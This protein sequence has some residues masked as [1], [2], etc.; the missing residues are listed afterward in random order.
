MLW[1]ICDKLWVTM[2]RRKIKMRERRKSSQTRRLSWRRLK[3]IE[4]VLNVTLVSFRCFKCV[5]DDIW[6]NQILKNP[7][8]KYLLK[9]NFRNSTLFFSQINVCFITFCF[10]FR[11]ILTLYQTDLKQFKSQNDKSHFNIIIS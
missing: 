7:R 10:T 6:R 9:I 3:H 2:R 8:F 4:I 5:F 1:S 11:Y